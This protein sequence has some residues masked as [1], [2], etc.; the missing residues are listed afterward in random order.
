MRNIAL[1]VTIV[2]VF[3]LIVVGAYVTAA[4]DG[5]ACGTD[6]GS[7]W[8]LCNGNVLPPPQTGPVAEYMH[9][10][11]ASLSALFLFVT[12]FLFWRA[13]GAETG[14]RRALYLASLLIVV[15]IVLGGAVVTQELEA[16]LVTIHQAI[17][18]LIF[19]L[20]AVAGALAFRR[21]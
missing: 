13:K 6:L 4:G 10:I 19:G 7:D 3:L 8:P 18:L 9:R 15:E 14:I 21:P 12:T 16:L 5:A 20:T 2:L 17:A 1:V 11:L